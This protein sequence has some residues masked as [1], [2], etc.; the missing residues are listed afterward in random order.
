MYKVISHVAARIADSD[1]SKFWPNARLAIRQAALDGSIQIYGQKSEDT[2]NSDA[3]SWSGGRIPIPQAYWELADITEA[4]TSPAHANELM[5]NTR[6][7]R[8]SDG[9]FTQEK[10]EYYTKLTA[11]WSDVRQKWP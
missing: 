11:K 3:T 2:G 8:L 9:R 6:P 10:I 4:A 5:S 7:H 1:T